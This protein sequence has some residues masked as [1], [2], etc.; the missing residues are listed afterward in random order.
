MG[1]VHLHLHTEYSLLDGE[2]RISAIPE[3]V[4]KAGQNAVAITDHGVLYGIV[5]FYKACKAT[6]V[7]PIIGCEVYVAPRSMS[8]KVHPIDGDYSHLV[9]LVKDKKGYENL[10]S[11]VSKSFTQGFYKKPRTDKDTLEKYSEGLIALSGCISGLIPKCIINGDKSLARENAI[12]FRRIFGRDNFYLELQRHGIDKQAVVNETLVT[13]SGELDIPLAATND[14][15]YVNQS[16]SMLQRLLMAIQM[17]KTIDEDNSGTEDGFGMEGNRFYLTSSQEMSALF[18]DLPEAIT[19][20]ERIAER[21]NFDFDFETMHLPAFS[22]PKP[23]TPYDYLVKLCNDGYT[24]K[25]E[26]GFIPDNCEYSKR[27]EYELSVIQTM[28]FVDYYLIVRDFVA[29]AKKRRIPVG[30]GRGSGVGSLCAYFLGITDVDPIKFGLL[31]ERFL[32]PERVSMPDFDIDFCDER[33]NE[34]IDYV[35]DKYGRAHVAQIVTFG[36]LACRQAVRDTGRALGMPYSAVDEIAKL[37]PR[38][39]GVSID[40]AIR[41]SKELKS[42]Y[43]S[44]PQAKRLIA[45]ARGL[46]GRPRNTSTHATGV[47]ITDKPLTSYVPLAL[48]DSITVTQFSMNTVAELGLLKIDFLGLRYLTIID[49]TEKA[50]KGKNPSFNPEKI[51]FD[52]A[53]TYEVLSSGNSLGLFQL[54]SE[55]MRNLLI[56]MKPFEFEDI[57]SAISLYRPGPMQS[58]ERFLQN[59][60]NPDKTEYI[61]P[62]LKE[63]LSSTH[64]CILYQEQVMQICRI[65]AG[66]SYGR[67]DIVRRAMAKKKEDAMAKERLGFLKGATERGVAEDKATVI[68]DMMNEFAKYAFNKSHAVAYAVIAYK[69]AYLKCHYPKEYMCSLLNSVN[70]ENSKIKEYIDDCAR[71]GIAILPPDINNSGEMFTVS[72]DN[73]RFGL[74]AV[75]NVGWLFAQKLI[76]ER[77]KSAFLSIEDFLTRTHSFGNTRMIE[78]LILCGALDCFGIYRSRLISELDNALDILS[79]QRNNNIEGQVGLFDGSVNDNTM[80]RLDFRQINEY[81]L[82]ERLSQEK[83]LT[84]LYFSGHPLDKYQRLIKTTGAYTSRQLLQG[85]TEGKI[86]EKQLVSFVALVTKKRTKVTKSNNIMAF[87]TAEDLDGEA[88]IILFPTVYEEYGGRINEGGIYIFECEATLKESIKDDTVDEVKLLLKS[89]RPADGWEQDSDTALYLKIT[90]KNATRLDDALAIIKES[91]GKSRVCIYFER[92][93]KLRAAKDIGCTIDDRLI[94]QLKLILGEAYV[95]TKSV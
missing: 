24:S 4:K 92:E 38:Y 15:H 19:N 56:R 81:P 80:L 22:A 82:L 1:F 25:K 33:R 30:P 48:N 76:L 31:F 62:E 79:K 12:F 91:A 83:A 95:A 63:I 37:L 3:A 71:M 88:E 68:F 59:R 49:N 70:G 27:L 52:D 32:N 26:E 61:T 53:E 74:V 29:F 89:V 21:C 43:A 87:V 84:G 41:E 36:T 2:C 60:R 54:E 57:V 50:I 40:S 17:G 51:P 72:G 75:K 18:A 16:D 65:L 64:G 20:T 34:V 67:A 94:S 78:S 13:L 7:K 47:V 23:Y 93:K 35:S 85:L 39:T 11:I 69:T 9:L 90:E 73:L 86:R 46:E 8:D 14:V 5:D 77:N 28:G 42:I 44:D 10:M 58:I 45:F 66:Y 55:G 6:G